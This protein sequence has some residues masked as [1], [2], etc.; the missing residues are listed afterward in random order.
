MSERAERRH[1]VERLKKK[2][3]AHWGGT[4]AESPKRLAKAVVTPTPCS[5][6]TCGNSRKWFGEETIQERR[7]K[8][9]L[10]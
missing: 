3:R 10:D 5:C 6:P 9:L 7:F 8:Q 4:I 2:R 1:Q